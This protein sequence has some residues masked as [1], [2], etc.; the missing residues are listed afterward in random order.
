M[1]EQKLTGVCIGNWHPVVWVS[2]PDM[3]KKKTSGPLEFSD[4]NLSH[5]HIH[6]Y[7]NIYRE[8]NGLGIIRK[9]PVAE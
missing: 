8:I 9:N 2:E 1:K 6:I 7:K 3:A 5:M 4:C